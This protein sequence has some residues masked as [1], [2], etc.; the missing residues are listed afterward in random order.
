[1]PSTIPFIKKLQLLIVVIWI[2]WLNFWLRFFQKFL[3]RKLKSAPRNILIYKVGN[4]G[5][6]ACAV[7]S[8]IAIR[9]FYPDSKIT[10]LTSPGKRGTLGAKE[11]L[12]DVWYLD[13]IGLYYTEDID[14]LEKKISFVKRLRE[15]KYDLLIQ[16]PDDL[17]N[18]QTVFRNLIFA[19]IIGAKSAFGFKI[20]TIQLFK[21]TQ[22]DFSFQKTETESL[23][24]LLKENGINIRKIEFDFNVSEEQ[25]NK[26]KKIIN[27]VLT[28]DVPNIN[29]KLIVAISPGGKRESNQWPVENFA[30]VAEYLQ[31][32]Y[33]AKIIVVG[34]KNDVSRAKI[35]ETK[36]KKGN[37]L[38]AAGKLDI[39][40]TFEL[41]KHC[42]F[43]ISNST[44][45]IHLAAAAGMPSIGLYTIR[46]VFGRWFPYGDQ[47]KVLFHKFLNCDYHREECIEQSLTEISIKE[48]KAA[49]DLLI[50][51][52]DNRD[53]LPRRAKVIFFDRDGVI[54]KKMS[55]NDYVKKWNEFEF[56]P[57][58]VEGL[59][60]LVDYGYKIFIVTNQRGISR[61]IMTEENLRDVH[62][63]MKEEL[64][65]LGVLLGGIYYC[66]HGLED[67]CECRKPKPG[68]FFR[69]AKEHSLDLSGAI[70]VGD[71]QSDIEAGRA[72]GVKTIL[73]ESNSNLLGVVRRLISNEH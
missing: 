63:R 53:N 42:S 51:D 13:D 49:C 12:N 70:F 16:L 45:T 40:E 61:G 10:L 30:E 67:N 52:L 48:V 28:S 54:N 9:R 22:V 58:V 34:G 57:G 4:I 26:V 72:A 1:M 17:A 11:L 36:L 37:L 56:N 43:L 5:D 71:S 39:L 21:K 8:F 46:D 38:I 62:H 20:R 64:V 25:K 66:P 23:I 65:G 60:I 24:D 31:N 50:R 69:A 32:R 3:F 2:K 7:P 14:S 19:E 35:I 18:F 47:H 6:I 44:G 29:G 33:D 27:N 55:G 68:L 73:V 41:L 15:K 59:K